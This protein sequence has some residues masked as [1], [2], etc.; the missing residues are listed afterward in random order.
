MKLEKSCMDDKTSER[1]FDYI[2]E[3]CMISKYLHI[4]LLKKKENRKFTIE[5]PGSND[6]HQKIEVNTSKLCVYIIG[7]LR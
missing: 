6:F 2:Q 7:L 4:Y 3:T 5:K 1:R